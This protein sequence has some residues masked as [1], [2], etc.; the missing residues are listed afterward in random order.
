LLLLKRELPKY[1]DDQNPLY[2]E[3]VSTTDL[4]D[5]RIEVYYLP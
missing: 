2:P 5:I 3:L 4:G 1:P